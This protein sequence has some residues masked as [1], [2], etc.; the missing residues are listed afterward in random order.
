M[1]KQFQLYLGI[2]LLF[3]SIP[4]AR[5]GPEQSEFVLQWSPRIVAAIQSSTASPCLASRNLAV[6]HIAAFDAVNALNPK[7]EPF[8]FR[9]APSGKIDPTLAAI[10]AIAYGAET[11]FPTHRGSFRALRNQQYTYLGNFVDNDVQT[12]SKKFGE[13]V[14]QLI[15]DQRSDDGSTSNL[16]YIPKDEIGKWKRTPPRYRPPELS[17]WSNTRPFAIETA[18]KFRLPAPPSLDS[19]SYSFALDEVRKI[20]AIDSKSRTAD[21]TEIAEFWSCFSYSSTPAGHWYEIATN[22]SREN[23]LHLIDTTRLLALASIAMADAGIAC[24]DTKYTYES[25]RPIQA[26]HAADKDGNPNTQPDPTWDSLLEAPPHPE[27]VSGHGAFSG[28]GGKILEL[29]FDE[30]EGY[31]FST[32]SSALP[33]VIR[34]FNSFAECVEEICDSRLYGGIHFRYS[35]DLGRD[36]GEQIAEYVFETKLRPLKP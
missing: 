14:A 24:W 7:Y 3:A 21:Q 16:T 22:L 17:Y 11:L 30:Q 5:S 1:N 27:Y 6:I 29:Y 26:I 13:Q 20:G 25:W 9:D 35:N 28:A 4:F 36:L 10:S 15:I 23:D 2:L 8:A 33:G 32:T 18:S 31:S 34:E 12:R 19:E